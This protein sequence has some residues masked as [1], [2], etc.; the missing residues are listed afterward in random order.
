MNVVE[1][2]PQG[3]IDAIKLVCTMRQVLPILT[4]LGY[5]VY[6]F[7]NDTLSRHTRSVIC[8]PEAVVWSFTGKVSIITN[9]NGYACSEHPYQD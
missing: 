8:C 1:I 7:T 9:L 4:K 6:S 3:A 5:H 2:S